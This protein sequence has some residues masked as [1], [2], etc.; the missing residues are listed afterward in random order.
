[1]NMKRILL[2]FVFLYILS[3]CAREPGDVDNLGDGEAESQSPGDTT[4]VTPQSTKPPRISTIVLADGQ[5]VAAKPVL[6]LNFVVGGRLLAVHVQPGDVVEQG[7]VLATLDGTALSNAVTVAELQAAQAETTLAQA[8]LSLEDLINWEP[9]E[10]TVAL[11]EANLVAAEANYESALVHDSTATNSLTSAR[12][13][14]DQAERALVDVQKA[15][16]QAWDSARDWELGIPWRKE[17][18]EYER[19]A[20]ARAV[21]NAGEALEVTRANYNLASAG[22]NNNQAL[23]AEANIA[24]AR[25]ALNQART[26]PKESDIAG[27]RLQ[28]ELAK[29][30]SEQAAFNLDQAYQSLEDA[31]LVAPWRGTILSVDIA[32]GAMVGGGTPILTLL[33]VENLQFNTTNLSERDLEVIEPGQTVQ[34]SLKT[35]PGREFSGTVLRI[36]PHSSGVVGDAAIFVVVVNLE[37]VDLLLLPGMTGRAEIQREAEGN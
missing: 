24:G 36:V 31:V 7:A 5:L 11:A 25:Q 29:L 32:P 28:V 10:T 23:N 21:Q 3:G 9:D 35:Y 19:D 6:P 17:M 15:Y 18:L 14:V 13:S 8:Q 27:A 33:D 26:G 34:I 2:L 12:V 22:L 4:L 20:T 30:S 37:P 16:D 1:M